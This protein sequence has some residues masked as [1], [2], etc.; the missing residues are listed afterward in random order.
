[1]QSTNSEKVKYKA[2]GIYSY[3]NNYMENNT[4]DRSSI[5]YLCD[6]MNYIVCGRLILTTEIYDIIMEEFLVTSTYHKNDMFSKV[7]PVF[8]SI[9]ELL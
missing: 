5:K 1:M 3:L 2:M 6:L 4:F 7:I 9:G 8:A